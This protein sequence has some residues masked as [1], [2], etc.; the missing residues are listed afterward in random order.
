MIVD[1]KCGRF[2]A[3]PSY[4]NSAQA[5]STSEVVCFIKDKSLKPYASAPDDGAVIWL[6]ENEMFPDKSQVPC[7]FVLSPTGEQTVI[8][9]GQHNMGRL[10]EMNQR[11]LI[12]N[13]F[14]L[15]MIELYN[16]VTK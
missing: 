12:T 2:E 9:R 8:N 13:L 11:N 7:D 15:T 16:K 5:R 3:V 4:Y 10:G 14:G 6:R 1:S